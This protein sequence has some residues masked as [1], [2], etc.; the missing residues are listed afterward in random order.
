MI[1]QSLFF[2]PEKMKIIRITKPGDAGVMQLQDAEL[3]TCGSGDVRISVYAAGVNRPDIFQRKGNYPAPAGAPADIPGLEVSGVVSAC[4][5]SVVRWKIGDR[6]CALLAG[7]GYAEEVCVP[8]GHCLPVPDT[9]NFPEAASLP[10]TV[11]TVW[12]NVFQ[13]GGLQPGET[14]L[15]HG[16]TS[17]I[18][19]SAIQI[20]RAKGATVFST[21][22]STEKCRFAEDLGSARS[23]NYHEADFAEIMGE[24]SVDV[25]LDMVGEKYFE[26]NVRVLRPD[27]RLVFINAVSGPEVRLSVPLLMKKRL[28]ITGSTLRARDEA[29]KSTLIRAVEEQVWPLI[30]SGQFRPVIHAVFPLAE[31]AAAHR[32][33]EDGHHIGK[34]VL[35]V[36]RQDD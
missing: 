20:A 22:G 26:Q 23:I 24:N 30:R 34:V 11:C 7:G 3:P 13:R 27:G 21:S 2:M 31:A 4:G 10:E 14:F 18:G 1:H 17:G 12:S 6:V 32:C 29:F 8:A 35:E 33:L 36:R 28:S 19:V 16:G 5:D 9:L 25:I 15:V